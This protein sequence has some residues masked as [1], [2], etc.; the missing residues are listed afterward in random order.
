[1][2]ITRK[3]RSIALASGVVG[4]LYRRFI[5]TQRPK[6]AET[7]PSGQ[8]GRG[9]GAVSSERGGVLHNKP[10]PLAVASARGEVVGGPGVLETLYKSA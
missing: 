2:F 4:L 7:P 6:K 3:S 5:E 1:M 8:R 10:T 9:I